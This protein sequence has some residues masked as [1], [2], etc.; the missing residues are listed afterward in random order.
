MTDTIKIKKVSAADV[1]LINE[2][3]AHHIDIEE[4]NAPTLHHLQELVQDDRCFLFVAIIDDII[5]GYV[6]AYSFPSLY[7]SSRMAYL[8]DIDVIPE[9]RKKGIG[10]HL[11]EAV[12]TELQK[13]GVTELWL[14]TGI[15][16][17]P[18][19]E[20]FNK[21]GG[22]KSGETFYDYTFDL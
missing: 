4:K 7:A 16:N 20:L 17:M 11:M 22:V 8:Y 9:H 21:T 1:S 13:N 12:K 3:L 6:L 15:D 14:G 2:L 19:Q 10:R 5:I 18:A